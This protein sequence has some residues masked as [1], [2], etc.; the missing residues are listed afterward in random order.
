MKGFILPKTWY[1]VIS[2]T[3]GLP[4]NLMG[5]AA[6]ACLMLVGYR[7]QKN[8]YGYYFI[9]GKNW[10]GFNMGV[11]SI[12]SEHPSTHTLHH[13]FGHSIQTCIFGPFIFFFIAIPSVIRYWYRR[14]NPNK[15]HP[16]Y[17][18]A[19]FEWLATMFGDRYAEA[20]GF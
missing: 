11:I 12:V 1:W 15:Q 4:L 7:P 2:L 3:W 18:Y 9:V 8:I 13:E 14:F 6:A 19:W 20:V 10:G 17:D 5:F 16:P